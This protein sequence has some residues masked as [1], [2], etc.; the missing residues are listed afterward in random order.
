[1]GG[2]GMINE[3]KA[4]ET[5]RNVELSLATIN[6]REDGVVVGRDGSVLLYQRG[7]IDKVSI[8]GRLIKDN[9]F[10]H[11]HHNGMCNLSVGDVVSF[12]ED[13]GYEVRVITPDRRFVSL[14]RGDG[15]KNTSLGKDM[16]KVCMSEPFLNEIKK[17]TLKKY[18]TPD[19]DL[20][21]I[22]L[23]EAMNNW[24]SNHA[25]EYG[26]IFKNGRYPL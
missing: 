4:A 6:D 1:V 13:D 21:N 14:R 9:I 10:T 17:R 26:Y 12:I 3:E 5:L 15:K 24:L 25:S 20:Q 16:K 2:G 23:E 18:G 22:L 19:F 7:T 11:V 8:D